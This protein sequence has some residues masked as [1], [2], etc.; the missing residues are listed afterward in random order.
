MPVQGVCVDRDT[1][2]RL[3]RHAL[4]KGDLVV[5][6]RGELGRC[7]VVGD[8]EAGW[9]CGT[10]CLLLRLKKGAAP[11]YV[12]L[13]IRSDY[14]RATLSLSSVGSIMENLNT[15]LLGRLKIPLPPPEEQVAILG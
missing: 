14:S 4:S 12:E 13:A 2:S 7:A 3:Q 9:L 5:A 1:A 6:R 10:G 11:S 8:R 15:S